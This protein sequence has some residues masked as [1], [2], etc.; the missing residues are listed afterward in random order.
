VLGVI[1]L[2]SHRDI[3]DIKIEP[4]FHTQDYLPSSDLVYAYLNT[5][6]TIAVDKISVQ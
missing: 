4:D 6:N 2:A 3:A 5:S 1:D